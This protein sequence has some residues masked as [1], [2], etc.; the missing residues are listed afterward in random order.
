MLLIGGMV[1]A[2]G[3]L[4]NKEIIFPEVAAIAVGALLMP[5]PAWRT[6]ALRTFAAI[7]VCALLGLGIV[8]WMPGAVWL[9]MSAAY[10][11]ASGLFH[12]SRTSFA[13]MISAAVLPVLLQTKSPVYPVAACILTAA[14]LLTRRVLIGC[15]IPEPAPFEPLP[16]PDAAVW[17][18]AAVRWVIASAVI[19]AALK[20]GIRYAAAPP[21]LV[22]FTEFWKPEA[23][24][25]KRPF[26]VIALL[27][28][29]AA[30]A[31]GIRYLLSVL[32]PVPL[33]AAAAVTVPAVRYIMQR[34]SLM[35]P[36]AA[37]SAILAYL[38]PEAALLRFPLQIMCGIAAL[39]G[40]SFLFPL[41]QRSGGASRP[42]NCCK[43]MNNL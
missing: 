23:V 31:A 28:L 11:I 18:Q 25:R 9:Q 36:P 35:L 13:P 1:G 27:T 6:C 20:C 37:A 33:W 42:A 14:I 38:I 8:L 34:M 19:F 26:A 24:S 40:A 43:N 3:A 29:C 21:L 10:L 5:K 30:C 41:F 17:M 15:A 12:L 39:T 4:H 7:A 32:L 22:A 2:A 16:R